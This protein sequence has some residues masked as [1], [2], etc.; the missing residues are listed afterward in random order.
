MRLMDTAI[1]TIEII[2]KTAISV[3][4]VGGALITEIYDT[5]KEN[6]LSK[7]QEQWR[8]SLEERL[9]KIDNALAQVKNNELFTT[10]LIK[11]TELAMKTSQ[12]EKISYLANAVANSLNTELDEDKLIIFFN[13]LDKYTVAHV[14]IIH[15]LNNPTRFDGISPNQ[16]MM[17]SPRNILFRVYPDLDNELF[18]KIYN[19]LYTDGM[20]S[21]QNLNITMSGAG[22]VAK[23]TTLLGDEFLEFIISN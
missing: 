16:Y 4:P 2:A 11:A 23:R 10:A 21:L 15:F 17:G 18:E 14:Q 6:C 19:D 20:V 3:I 12:I 13:L 1:D 22:M 8:I 5:V 9:N 7:R